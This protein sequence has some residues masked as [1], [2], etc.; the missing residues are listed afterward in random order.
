MKKNILVGVALVSSLLSVTVLAD[1]G[2]STGVGG[3]GDTAC[4]QR[5]SDVRQDILSWIQQGGSQGLDFSKE[6]LSLTDYN[7][8]MLAVLANH[9]VVVGCLNE[10]QDNP[11]PV[12]VNNVPKTCRGY[13]SVVDNLQ[14]IDCDLQRFT[15]ATSESDQ[16]S[17]VHHEFAGLAGVEKNIGASSDYDI[18]NQITEYLV[19]ETV[20]KLAIKKGTAKAVIQNPGVENGETYLR[21]HDGNTADNYNYSQFWAPILAGGSN[22]SGH[23]AFVMNC[24][25]VQDCE[26]VHSFDEFAAESSPDGVC[27]VLGYSKALSF[28]KGLDTNDEGQFRTYD[29]NGNMT[30]I[31]QQKVRRARGGEMGSNCKLGDPNQSFIY[32]TKATAIFTSVTCE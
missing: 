6:G 16:Y 17:L 12:Q 25:Y 11:N 26:T 28:T 31:T 24:T 2:G 14:H 32:K 29:S 20:L 18:S 27:K 22:L 19:S 3:G 4:E 10:T 21:D 7:S 8:K 13:V 15:T 1:K 23:C 5:I 9:A 30:A